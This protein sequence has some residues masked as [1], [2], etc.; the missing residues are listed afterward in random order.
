MPLLAFPTVLSQDGPA[1]VA[2]AWVLVHAGD[3]GEVGALLREHY[4][5]DLSPVPNMLATLLLAGLLPAVGPDTAERLLVLGLVAGLVAALAYA[6]RGL[7]RRAWWLAVAALPLAGSHLMAYGFY[8]FGLGIVGFL[9]AL[10][11]ALRRRSG[12][13]PGAVAGLAALLLLTWTA[14]L[15]PWAVALGGVG[16]L[17]LA[18][19][20]E[21]LRD[22]IPVGGAVRRELLPVL[23]ASAPSA[24]LTLAYL[25]T[26][27]GPAG[28]PFGPPTSER[29]Q[30]LLSGVRPF[31]VGWG[32]EECSALA[33][34]VAL[35]VLAATALRRLPDEAPRRRAERTALAVLLVAAIVAYGLT[36]E[37]LGTG[38]G[39]L[40]DRLA[41]F[42]ALLLA[43]WAG[44]RPPGRRVGA[45]LAVV[46]V[47]AA[48]AAVLVR[49]PVQAQ[50]AADVRE[51]L[52]VAEEIPPGSTF[53]VLQYT[54]GAGAVPGAPDP[55]RH[56]SSRLAVRTGGVDLGHYEAVQP[57][58]QVEFVGPRLRERLDPG[59]SG[60][61]RLP[62]R[63][64]LDAVRGEL[65]YVLVVGLDRAGRRVRE[66]ARTRAVAAELAAHYERVATSAPTGLVEV[67]RAEQ[68]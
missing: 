4:R 54:R 38:F 66:S 26:G 32:G 8:N 34:A 53:V 12:W 19:V 65:D 6:L 22:G 36:P 52:S 27:D 62:P 67:W 9:L 13:S 25:R 29:L 37:R 48:S 55:L 45:L 17:A 40:E 11:F 59:L 23:L 3:D 39:F 35:A 43:L 58:F 60:L 56:E 68:S 21:G 30:A 61:E 50:A 47:A 57:Y 14:H 33:A 20:R 1:H 42:P 28:T 15:L 46:V 51:L 18:R 63:V 24:V 64:E 44:T 7:S 31:V 10:G 49:L 5:V 41:W 16:L 2:G